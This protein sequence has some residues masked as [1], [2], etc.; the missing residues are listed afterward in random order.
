[1]QLKKMY[2]ICNKVQCA[3]TRTKVGAAFWNFISAEQSFLKFIFVE[4]SETVYLSICVLFPAQPYYFM[5]YSDA[6]I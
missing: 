6:L 2:V 4:L 5:N 1:M 3:T